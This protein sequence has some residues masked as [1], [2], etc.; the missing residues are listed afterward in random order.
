MQNVIGGNA[1]KKA[2]VTEHYRGQKRIL[3]IGCSV[4]N[5]SAG[6]RVFPNVAFTGIDIDRHA[7]ELAKRRFRNASNFRFSLSSLEELSRRGEIFDYVIFAGMLH[8]V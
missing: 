2:L 8:N 5:V 1:C 4:G 7:I 3:E 6:F